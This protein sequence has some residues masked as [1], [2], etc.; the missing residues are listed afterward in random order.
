M[1]VLSTVLYTL[2]CFG[3]SK[4]KLFTDQDI[5]SLVIVFF[6]LVTCQFDSDRLRGEIRFWSLLGVKGI[7]LHN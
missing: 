6:I 1:H 3:T 7:S 2:F 5:L 4:E